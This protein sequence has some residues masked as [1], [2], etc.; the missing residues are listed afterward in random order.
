MRTTIDLS[1]EAY[2]VAKSIAREQNRSLS[3]VVSDLILLSHTANSSHDNG[4]DLSS[5][6][7]TFRCI[8]RVTSAD[9]AALEDEF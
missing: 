3:S 8:R 5:G 4:I 6:F 9:V 1:D 2:H 7:P